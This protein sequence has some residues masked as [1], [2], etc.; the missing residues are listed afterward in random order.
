M[1]NNNL[2][3][4]ICSGFT[5]LT[6]LGFEDIIRVI[7]L[8]LGCVSALVSL[9]YNIYCWYKKAKKDGKIDKDEIK[10]LNDVINKGIDDVKTLTDN[11]KEDKNNG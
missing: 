2:I 5:I 8:V 1:K 6:S 9:A 10:E 3:S 11:N 7:L 4:W